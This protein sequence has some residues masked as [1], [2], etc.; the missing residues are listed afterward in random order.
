M[1]RDTIYTLY[2][3]GRADPTYTNIWGFTNSTE[4]EAFFNGKAHIR[5]SQQKYWRV[6][7][8]IKIPIRYEQA[9]QYDYII[10]DN[11]TTD[12]QNA[13]RW[14]GF[15]DA[16]AYVSPEVTLITISVDWIQTYYFVNGTPFWYYPSFITR[17]HLMTCPRT[18]HPRTI[19]YRK[20]V[21]YH[22]YKNRGSMRLSC[23]R[24]LARQ[25]QLRGI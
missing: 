12:S 18:A 19:Q 15:I 23:M 10:I 11:D 13:R 20:P 25:A 8:T 16:K 1:A 21:V 22:L 9:L 5:F 2:A 6:G 24:T 17:S 3:T 14:Y 7:A 4:R